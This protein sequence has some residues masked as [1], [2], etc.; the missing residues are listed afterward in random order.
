MH[1]IGT[2]QGMKAHDHLLTIVTVIAF[3]FSA[4]IMAGKHVTFGDVRAHKEDVGVPQDIDLA[5]LWT[6]WSLLE[7]K[8]VPL[9]GAKI[10]AKEDRVWGIIEGLANSYNDPY[11][12]F[13]SPEKAASFEEDISGEF[14]GIGVEIGLRNN[15]ITVIAPLK[16]TPAEQAGLRAGDSIV[17]INGTSTQGMTIDDAVNTIRGEV[18]TPVTLTVARED[19]N[20][21]LT[22][23]IVRDTIEIP[24]LESELRDDGVFV[25]SLYNFGGTANREIRNALRTFNESGADKLLIDLRGNPGGYLDVAVEMASWFLPVGKVIVTED[26][27]DPE[28]AITHRSKGYDIMKDSW[29]IAI[30]VNEGSASASEIVAGAL[31]EH[32]VAVLIGE[33]TFGKGSVQEL[34]DVTETTALKI[35]IARWLTPNG[36]SISNNGLSPNLEVGFSADDYEVGIDN[37]FE[38]AIQYLHT[39]ELVHATTAETSGPHTESETVEGPAEIE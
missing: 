1:T 19:E 8:F 7:E 23:E 31:Q 16:G 13:L 34:V 6:A 10:T 12:V 32:G 14:G 29:R 5:P 15:V 9:S 24:T 25:L 18:G 17:E 3:S 36:L 20:E 11:T 26:Y 4:G 27:G 28:R 2:I 35:T 38:T 30:L 39:G 33:A 22:I 21:F 37:Q